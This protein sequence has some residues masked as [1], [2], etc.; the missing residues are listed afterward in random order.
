MYTDK[1][2]RVSA[3]QAVTAAAYSADVIDLG[4]RKDLGMGKEIS[5]VISV[6]TT[7]TSGGSA[8]VDFQIVGS[9]NAD[10]SSHVV[11]G[12][13]GAQAVASI[14][15]PKQ[16]GIKINPDLNGGLGYRYLGIRYA[17]ATANLT[18]GAFTADF[19]LTPNDS[20]KFYP[21]GYSVA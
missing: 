21:S 11:L 6:D 18:A 7:A 17:V 12:S 20:K 10:L 13:T 9:A 14:T 8:T 16:Y 4:E 15:S 19:V 3:A 1:D 5:A 2:L